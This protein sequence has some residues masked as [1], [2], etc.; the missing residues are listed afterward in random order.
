[1]VSIIRGP[2][3]P[4]EHYCN[5]EYYKVSY[6]KRKNLTKPSNSSGARDGDRCYLG[7]PVRGD[8]GTIWCKTHIN[9]AIDGID[10]HFKV[11]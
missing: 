9:K 7:T 11:K 8:C 6:E 4:Q 5:G 1:M 3:E 2:T 10:I